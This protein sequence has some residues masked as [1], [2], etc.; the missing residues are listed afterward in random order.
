ML[1]TELRSRPEPGPT[2][3]TILCPSSTMDTIAS[4]ACWPEIG[5]HFIKNRYAFYKD[6]DDIQCRRCFRS[7]WLY[8]DNFMSVTTNYDGHNCF[9]SLLPEIGMHFI[10]IMTI[11]NVVV[12]FGVWC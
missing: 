4:P 9:T 12:A 3:T 2:M 1:V 8:Y 11:G 6:N 5:M 10:K 7:P